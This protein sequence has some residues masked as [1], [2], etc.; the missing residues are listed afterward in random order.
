MAIVKHH[1]LLHPVH[2]F[3]ARVAHHLLMH[4][5]LKLT[6][7]LLL[8]GDQGAAA[9]SGFAFFARANSSFMSLSPIALRSCAFCLFNY[10]SANCIFS[11]LFI[12]KGVCGSGCCAD[13]PVVKS[14]S[15]NITRPGAISRCHDYRLKNQSV[16]M[17]AFVRT[18]RLICTKHRFAYRLSVTYAGG[19]FGHRNYAGLV[20][21]LP[22]DW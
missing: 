17:T 1:L 16:S 3:H 19:A 12:S 10:S 11:S 21:A 4:Q 8:L 6:A 20:N 15:N 7:L 13:N 18:I 5:Q 22:P 2:V 9:F 14:A